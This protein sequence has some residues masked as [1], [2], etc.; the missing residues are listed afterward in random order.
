MSLVDALSP[1]LVSSPCAL[2]DHAYVSS[3]ERQTLFSQP[4][5]RGDA[6]RRNWRPSWSQLKTSMMQRRNTSRFANVRRISGGAGVALWNTMSNPS[7]HPL[8][9]S[10]AVSQQ[11]Q[12]K[13]PV[14]T[15]VRMITNAV[16]T[17]KTA[18]HGKSTILDRATLSPEA[19]FSQLSTV[20]LARKILNNLLSE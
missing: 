3:N 6:C 19:K 11:I 20:E 5:S 18:G 14:I 12:R 8:S 2:L 15:F 4:N 9:A 1:H 16:V 7:V 10:I 17:G 13:F